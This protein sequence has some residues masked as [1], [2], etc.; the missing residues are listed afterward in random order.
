MNMVYPIL[1]GT[2]VEYDASGAIDPR[3][4]VAKLTKAGVGVMTLADPEPG[5]DGHIMTIC[6]TTA[7]AHTVTYTGGFGGIGTGEDVATFQGAI[8]ESMTIRAVDGTWFI[9]GLHTVALG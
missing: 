3:V 8:G 7:Q 5:Y 6:T 1:T 2:V 4:S 9:V